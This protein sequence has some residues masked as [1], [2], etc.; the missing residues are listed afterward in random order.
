MIEYQNYEQAV[1]VSGDGDFQCL[2]NYL[3][4]QIKLTAVLIPN[5]R[6]YSA[7][8][9]TAAIKPYLRFASDLR[10]KLEQKQKNPR[11]DLPLKG[12]SSIRDACM[13]PNRVGPSQG[14][15]EQ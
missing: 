10:V 7:L 13:I 9:K 4:E 8:L 3:I 11:K 12:N 14:G 6:K 15:R 2:V 1:I 5:Q